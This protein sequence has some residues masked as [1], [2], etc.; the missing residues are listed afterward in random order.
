MLELPKN[1]FNNIIRVVKLGEITRVREIRTATF[2]TLKRLGVERDLKCGIRKTPSG[3]DQ[4]DIGSIVTW[5][6]KITK[7]DIAAIKQL[8][9]ID[10]TACKRMNE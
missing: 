8:V 2:N 1:H 6:K 10:A 9:T 3:S 5:F 4:V 7:E